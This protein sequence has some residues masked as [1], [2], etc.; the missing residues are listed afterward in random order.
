MK[1]MF[2]KRRAVIGLVAG[3]A[4]GLA[5][6]MVPAVGSHSHVSGCSPSHALDTKLTVG[7]A[8]RPHTSVEVK[9]GDLLADLRLCLLQGG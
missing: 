5:A 8:S 4:I 3:A 7:E 1:R 9:P 2:T 6:P